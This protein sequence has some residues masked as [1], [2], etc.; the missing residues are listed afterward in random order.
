MRPLS[1]VA[2]E[3]TPSLPRA[4]QG[5][6]GKTQGQFGRAFCPE[7]CCQTPLARARP[8]HPRLEAATI[9]GPKTWVAGPSP[10]TGILFGCTGSCPYNRVQF[11][12][13]PCVR[14]GGRDPR[15]R[16]DGGSLGHCCL[17]TSPFLASTDCSA[18]GSTHQ[19]SSPTV[20]LGA[21]AG[22]RYLSQYA[23]RKAE[24]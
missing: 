4:R 2:P 20:Y 1:G 14:G 3:P 11:P 13:Q 10:A 8:G 15:Q 6:P 16:Q 19:V 21:M 24:T 17:T 5:C 23:T 9:S 12:G 22:R 7:S 18:A